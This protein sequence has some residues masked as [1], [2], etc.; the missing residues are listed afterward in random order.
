MKITLIAHPKSKN[1]K[2]VKLDDRYFEAYFFAVPE[3]GKANAKLIQILSDYFEVS[4]SSI[5][6]LHGEKSTMKIIE[7]EEK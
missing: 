5:K 7:I 1:Q 6:I 4:P 2:I 3:K